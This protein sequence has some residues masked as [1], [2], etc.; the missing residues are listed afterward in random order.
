MYSLDSP[1]SIHEFPFPGWWNW[2]VSS[3]IRTPGNSCWFWVQH[4]SAVSYS[5]P[6]NHHP[7]IWRKAQRCLA[8]L[9]VRM[10]VGTCLKPVD[11]IGEVSRANLS[12]KTT[13]SFWELM[14][15]GWILLGQ[16]L[17]NSHLCEKWTALIW[18][19]FIFQWA[20][21]CPQE[22]VRASLEGGLFLHLFQ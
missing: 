14:I 17:W 18:S 5:V 2:W 20:S 19:Y 1:K 6:W 21:E 13:A 11:G 22:V 4:L 16:V 7:E 12:F 10:E 15:L 8:L 3:S 9:R